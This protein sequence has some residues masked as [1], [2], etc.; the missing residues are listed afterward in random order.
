MLSSKCFVST[1]KTAISAKN[2][3]DNVDAGL[4]ATLMGMGFE[5]EVVVNALLIT[6]NA[7]LIE[8]LDYLQKYC[9][10]AGAEGGGASDKTK[11][12]VEV[13]VRSLSASR[14]SLP[15]R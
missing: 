9:L 15:F 1:P 2:M 11:D 4:L 12:A 14:A 7:S 13:Q 5:R 6:N 3:D 10:P 8:A